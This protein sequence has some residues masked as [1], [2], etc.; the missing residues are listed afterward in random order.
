MM[1]LEQG[2]SKNH[3]KTQRSE[4]SAL[5]CNIE[6]DAFLLPSEAYES[7][8]GSD[9]RV[10]GLNLRSTLNNMD[11]PTFISLVHLN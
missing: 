1:I 7:P 10:F 4:Q 6:E 5:Q 9:S 8:N 2:W 3:M 11:H